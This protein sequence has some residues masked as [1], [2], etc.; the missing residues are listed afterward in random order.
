MLSSS[1]RTIKLWKRVLTTDKEH[2]IQKNNSF[3]ERL[4][5]DIKQIKNSDKV[6]VS[7]DKSWH[8]YKLGQSE[9]KKLLKEN[10][11]KTYKKSTRQTVNYVNSNAQGITEKLPIS[12]R[13][14][15]L[16]ETEAYCDLDETRFYLHIL[17]I[18][19]IHIW[20]FRALNNH[21]LITLGTQI[22]KNR[23]DFNT[24]IRN[25]ERL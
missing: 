17:P 25:I 5:N 6:F 2:R 12:E 13:T 14:E 22:L 15:K 8:V 10:I 20:N 1:G 21:A 11:T 23:R 9:Y 24:T 18:L 16:Q 4:S 19:H 7:A 3:R